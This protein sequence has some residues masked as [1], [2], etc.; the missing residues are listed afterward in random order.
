MRRSTLAL[1]GLTIGIT[2]LMMGAKAPSTSPG[3][4]KTKPSQAKPAPAAPG[5]AETS[6]DQE[7]RIRAVLTRPVTIGFNDCPLREVIDYVREYTSVNII[8]DPVGLDILSLDP[9]TPVTLNL[10]QVPAKSVLNRLL[11]PLD[12]VAV[13]RDDVLLITAR[14]MVEE[15][16]VAR[17]YPVVDLVALKTDDGCVVIA[18]RLQELI[19]AT[20]A[21]CSWEDNGGEAAIRY[22]AVSASFVVRQTIPVHDE[23]SDLLRG[24]RVTAKELPTTIQSQGLPSKAQMDASLLQS[25]VQQLEMEHAQR[26]ARLK[27][28]NTLDRKAQAEARLVEAQADLAELQLKKAR[29]QKK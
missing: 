18:E 9:E 15:I 26:M 11:D 5:R 16:F 2:L 28:G 14:E 22:E 27:T 12:L 6:I 23:L 29:E 1:G 13:V 21:P 19:Q 10:E 3:K 8:L 17:I 4:A 24:L 25:E 7:A 20:V